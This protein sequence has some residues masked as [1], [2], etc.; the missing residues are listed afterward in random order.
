MRSTR[1][2]RPWWRGSRGCNEPP[3]PPCSHRPV[4]ARCRRR[5]GVP[6]LPDMGAFWHLGPGGRM[7]AVSYGGAVLTD[8]ELRQAYEELTEELQALCDEYGCMGGEK[9]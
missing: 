3:A 5:G 7:G 9:R 8:E 1:S 2:L 6:V 4:C